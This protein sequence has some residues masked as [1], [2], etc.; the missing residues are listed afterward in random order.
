MV[1]ARGNHVRPDSNLFSF[2]FFL[3]LEIQFSSGPPVVPHND[4]WVALGKLEIPLLTYL[5][6]TLVLRSENAALAL[7]SYY[8][9]EGSV[10]R[11][12]V[13]TASFT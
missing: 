13:C 5:T 4:P 8:K 1:R 6:T 11:W 12:C 3:Q 9:H 2:F 10:G 7:W